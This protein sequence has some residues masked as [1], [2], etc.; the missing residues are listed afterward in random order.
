VPPILAVDEEAAPVVDGRGLADDLGRI[1]FPMQKEAHHGRAASI[2][3]ARPAR[4]I[5]L[6][7]EP[8]E[9]AFEGRLGRKGRGRVG[10]GLSACRSL[11][12]RFD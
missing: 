2:E 5:A 10:H 7:G 6:A 12:E 3:A 8:F 4:D 11:E 1:L 9:G